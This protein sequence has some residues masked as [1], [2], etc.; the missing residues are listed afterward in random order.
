MNAA[1]IRSIITLVNAGWRPY[2]YKLSDTIYEKAQCPYLHTKS[3]RKPFWFVRDDIFLCLSCPKGCMLS[4]PEGAML[5]LPIQYKTG[6]RQ[7]RQYHSAP[8]ELVSRKEL[9]RV[10]EAAYCLN[11]SERKIYDWIAEGRL[12]RTKTPPV[13]V[14]AG[15][16]A[17]EMQ[18]IAD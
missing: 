4:R 2:N 8:A 6:R 16:V 13:R 12:R 7:G 14:I 3:K 17:A 5:P 15:D 18:N 1:S 11:V 9:L 10:D